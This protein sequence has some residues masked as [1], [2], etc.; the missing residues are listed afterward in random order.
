M[1]SSFY[2]KKL[3]L[4]VLGGGQLGRMLIQEAINLDVFVSILDPSKDAPCAEIANDF[5]CGDFN[6]E[7]SVYQFGRDKDVITVEIEHVS[8]PALERLKAEGVKVYPDPEVLKIIQDKGL[9]KQFFRLNK[10]PTSA[11]SLT[12]TREELIAAVQ[13]KSCVQKLR[14]GGYD[15]KGVKVISASTNT[16]DL[17]D[18][19]SVIEELVDIDQEISVIVA[20]NADGEVKTFPVVGMEFDAEA[21]LVDRLFSPAQITAAQETIAADLAVKLVE[22]FNFVGL[23]AV[24]MF[25]DKKG[26]ILI[27]EVAPRPHNSGHQTIEGN[28]TSQFAQHLRSILNLPLGATEIIQ[29][30]VMVNVL[31]APGFTGPVEYEGIESILKIPGCYPHLYGK[32]E[33]KPW[34]KMGHVTVLGATLEEANNKAS[35]VKKMLKVISK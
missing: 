16:A 21:N 12:A 20:R 30:S 24:E 4:G 23:M 14:T 7:E 10:I 5:V 11:Y 27:N 3:K 22:A 15:G 33:T 35:Q 28:Y 34:R 1:G 13:G 32:T 8:V 26:D 9:Q 18:G 2:G 25:I 31:G 29:P 19:P 17:L 6:D